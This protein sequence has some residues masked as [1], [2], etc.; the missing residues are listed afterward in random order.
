M[1]VRFFRALP[2]ACLLA[3]AGVSAQTAAPQL[4]LKGPIQTLPLANQLSKTCP[5]PNPGYIFTQPD[6]GLEE[7]AQGWFI[8]AEVHAAATGGGALA[9]CYYGLDMA[10]PANRPVYSVHYGMTGYTATECK[11]SGR[12]VTCTHQLVLEQKKK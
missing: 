12:T 2:L 1:N 9:Y 3:G 8:R 4:Q 5:N 6:G 7:S 11:V 10:A